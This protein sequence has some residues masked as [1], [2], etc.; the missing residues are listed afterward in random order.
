[1]EKIFNDGLSNLYALVIAIFRLY[2]MISSSIF[3]APV[4]ENLPGT[5]DFL[6][7]YN[8]IQYNK[9]R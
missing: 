7:L 4:R 1:M 6:I 9:I 3:A 5:R 8:E 2:F